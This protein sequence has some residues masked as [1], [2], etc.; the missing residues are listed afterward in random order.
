MTSSTE[1]GAAL[2]GLQREGPLAVLTINRPERLNAMSLALWRALAAQV[3][4]LSGETDLRCLILR[5][6]GGKAF[7]AGADI[8]EFPE[9]RFSREQA[10][11]YA[12]AIEPTLAALAACPIPTLAAIEGVCTGGALE[13]ALLCDLRISNESGRFGIPINRIGHCLPYPAMEALVELVGR[14]RALEILLEGRVV[15]AQE[16]YAM[17]MVNRVVPDE[18]FGEAIAACA[19]RIMGGAPL[20]ARRHK[21]MARRVLEPRSLTQAEKDSAYDLCDSADYR[22]GVT[23]FLEKRKPRFEGR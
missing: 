16:A 15:G 2:V 1:G 12:A 4:A 17:G 11:G 19:E 3:S 21:I 13:L 20:A 22:E 5:G 6:A 10:I 9:L 18:G 14:S 8:S 7:G 23:A